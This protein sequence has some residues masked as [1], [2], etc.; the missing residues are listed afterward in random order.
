MHSGSRSRTTARWRR[1]LVVCAAATLLAP[2][3]SAC[4]V[5]V[6]GE[7]DILRIGTTYP[8]DSLNPF[9]S[10]AD[11]AYV[12]Y[13][14]MYPALTQY[15]ADLHISPYFARSWSTSKNGKDW[16]FHTVPNARWSDGKPLNATDV[17]WT[18]NMIVHFKNGA[19]ASAAGTVANVIKAVATDPNTV[20]VHYSRP[21]A[22]VLEQLQQLPIL[23]RQVWGRLAVGNGRQLRRFQNSAPVVSGGPFILENYQTNHIA[24]FKD[25][26]MWWGKPPHIKG[27][28]LEFFSNADAMVSALE[29]GQLDMIGEYTPAT[30]VAALRHAKLDVTTAPSL[31]LKDF[32]INTNPKKKNH[33]ELLNPVVREAMDDAVDRAQIVRTA[34]L[35][36]AQPGNTLLA[37][38]DENWQNKA[39]PAPTFNLATANRLLDQA[40][41]KRGSNGIRIADGHPMSYSLL[42]LAD[43]RGP[44]DRT[45]QII[46][47]DFKTI[48]IRITED[49]VDDDAG[50]AAILA[51]NN[52]YQDFDLAMWDWVPPVD[53]DFLLSVLTCSQWGNNSDSGFCNAEYDRLYRQQAEAVNP[54]KRHRIVDRMQLIIHNQRPYLILDYPDVIEAHS[55][56]WTGF[57]QAPVMGSVNSLSTVTLLN[58]HRVA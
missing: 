36:Y 32:I 30:T 51:P 19:T 50:N 34:W 53:P 15:D 11:Y 5:S 1:A 35:G 43:E 31:S 57:V 9:V 45:F 49:A 33:R 7:R 22:N 27:F 2:F 14:Y 18:I 25:N 37:P 28:G 8:I 20:V 3:V 48:G 58:V 29:T 56:Q 54:V 16:T 47:N 17:A 13:Q 4:Q 40:G 55:R 44:G 23:P 52:K 24:L 38:A 12:A 41:Y 46:Q 10:E 6:A 26:P 21:V 42:F 39:I